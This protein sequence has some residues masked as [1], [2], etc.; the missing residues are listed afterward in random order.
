M[1]EPRVNFKLTHYRRVGPLATAA[2]ITLCGSMPKSATEQKL[3]RYVG[4][5]EVAEALG[6][7]TKTLRRMVNDGGFPQPVNLSPN[8]IGWMAHVVAEYMAS[9]ARDV[10]ARAVSSPDQ[11]S[12]ATVAVSAR[13]LA[14][15]HLA[16][17]FGEHVDPASVIIGRIKRMSPAEGAVEERELFASL[18]RQ[19]EA[20]SELE[21]IPVIYWL[22]PAYR[23]GLRHALL[24][25]GVELPTDETA[26]RAIG[27]G[28][29]FYGQTG[30]SATA[31]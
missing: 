10:T 1:L 30:R 2:Q 22:F 5:R 11:L 9:R 15:T 28:A 23:P 16:R 12:D 17:E 24:R 19:F 3:P 31:Q 18:E 29:L 14:A 25:R 26:I 8:R 13:Q 7:S 4:R 21:C 27:A 20:L 6:I